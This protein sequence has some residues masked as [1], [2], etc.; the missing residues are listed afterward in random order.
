VRN[1]PEQKTA[2]NRATAATRGTHAHRWNVESVIARGYATVTAYYGDL[3]ED[4]PEGLRSD[5]GALFGGADV[6]TR[7]TDA[8]GAIG[9]WAWGL[10]RALDCL[11]AD[12]E[13]DAT[14]VAVHGH[15]R[16]GKAALWAGAQDE[17]FAA[18]I[19]NDSGCG[20]AALSMRDYGETVER[21]NTAFPYW[22]ARNF[23]RYNGRE[24]EMPLDQHELLALIAPRPLH[25]ASAE[26]DRWA[27]PRGEFLALQA[28]EPVYRLFGHRGLGVTTM[29]AV[30]QTV[31]GDS[32]AYHI[33]PGPHDITPVDW[34]NYLDF[35]DQHLRKKSPSRDGH[36]R[37][38][39]R[40][41]SEFFEFSDFPIFQFPNFPRFPIS[42]CPPPQ[43]LPS[44]ASSPSPAS[45]QSS[46]SPKSSASSESLWSSTSSPPSP[47]APPRCPACSA[48]APRSYPTS[49]R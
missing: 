18:V 37:P 33:R 48:T 3:C 22:F 29:P 34:A 15:S 9:I 11:S 28:T 14:R 19:S 43:S 27:D 42:P 8:W 40:P 6:E 2:N 7:A 38:T 46:P 35:A 25:V 1:S 24:K 23:R 30:N 31:L 5:V 32:L 4:R 39:Q 45:S 12:P 21:I 20:G 10:S 13:I 49:G 26:D 41:I 17:R 36:R 47:P 16:L 44:Y